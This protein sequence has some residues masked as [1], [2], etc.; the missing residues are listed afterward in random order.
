MGSIIW[1]L[2]DGEHTPY[3]ISDEISSVLGMDSDRVLADVLKIVSD[4]LD[5]KLVE[6]S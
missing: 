6:A 5:N 3:E 1:Q 4:L 2:C